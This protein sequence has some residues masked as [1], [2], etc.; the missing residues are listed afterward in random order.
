[1]GR[2]GR[3][4]RHFDRCLDLCS[5]CRDERLVAQA[6]AGLG[7]VAAHKGDLIGGRRQ[8]E[9]AAAALLRHGDRA[10]AA[11]G[12]H[13][14]AV[15]GMRCGAAGW[16]AQMEDAAALLGRSAR[17]H[18][19]QEDRLAGARAR[20]QAWAWRALAR[21]AAELRTRMRQGEALVD[22]Q[23]QLGRE[24]LQEGVAALADLQAV[25]DE[26]LA[27]ATRRRIAEMQMMALLPPEQVCDH[28]S[29]INAGCTT[30]A[31]PFALTK[32]AYRSRVISRRLL[33]DAMRRC[34]AAGAGDRAGSWTDLPPEWQQ[35]GY[36][37]GRP[38][39]SSDSGAG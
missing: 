8:L 15:A 22:A 37:P 28:S 19:E 3:A 12:L 29:F 2:L 34:R 10:A 36:R 4:A 23:R 7:L 1:M 26:L 20:A 38:P 30:Q 21:E 32:W 18:R 25:G 33:S 9:E 17:L 5:E 13:E 24:A 16:Q 11:R 35:A 14:A 39:G 6:Q 27:A 31:Y